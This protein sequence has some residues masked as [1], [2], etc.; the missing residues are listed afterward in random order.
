MGTHPP[1]MSCLIP[2]VSKLKLLV[3]EIMLEQWKMEFGFAFCLLIG[4]WLVPL[5]I[6]NLINQ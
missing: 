1:I 2:R 3:D 6:N 5:L 4:Y